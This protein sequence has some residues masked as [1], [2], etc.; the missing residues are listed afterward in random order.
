MRS[1][2]YLDSFTELLN[3]RMSRQTNYIRLSWNW[4]DWSRWLIIQFSYRRH[5]NTP[6]MVEVFWAFTIE[7]CGEFETLLLLLL[8][9]FVAD[10]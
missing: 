9:D 1:E 7:Q 8:F 10:L 4:L 2:Y 5:G 3:T 6:E